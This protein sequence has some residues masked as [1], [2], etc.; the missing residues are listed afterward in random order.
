MNSF[1]L[2]PESIILFGKRTFRGEQR[3]GFLAGGNSSVEPRAKATS[4]SH[5]QRILVNERDTYLSIQC[6]AAARLAIA[7]EIPLAIRR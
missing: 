1:P 6:N 3:S 7:P 5:E 2:C 4:K